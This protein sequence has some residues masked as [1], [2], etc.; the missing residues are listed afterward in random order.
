M[1]PPLVILVH[2]LMCML[3]TNCLGIPRRTLKVEVLISM[4]TFS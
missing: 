3:F 2:Q 1:S 4:T